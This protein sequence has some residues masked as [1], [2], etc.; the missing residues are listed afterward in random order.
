MINIHAILHSSPL[1]PICVDIE[2]ALSCRPQQA[3]PLRPSGLARY[4]PIGQRDFTTNS[5][6]LVLRFLLHE[7]L[8]LQEGRFSQDWPKSRPTGVESSGPMFD[9]YPDRVHRLNF[10]GVLLT[11]GS[12][13]DFRDHQIAAPFEGGRPRRFQIQNSKFPPSSARG[14]EGSSWWH[15]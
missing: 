5:I 12:N 6:R 2:K 1:S 4:L 3:G 10:R 14:V 15:D 8:G 11:P 9:V 7:A 13:S